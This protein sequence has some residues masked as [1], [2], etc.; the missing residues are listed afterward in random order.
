MAR[1]CTTAPVRLQDRSTPQPRSHGSPPA[2]R[3]RSRPGRALEIAGPLPDT[4][5]L[6]GAVS[7]VRL[8][9]LAYTEGVGGSS[10]SPPTTSRARIRPSEGPTMGSRRTC[11]QRIANGRSADLLACLRADEQ[12]IERGR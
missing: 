6:A 2:L 11:C 9:H 4:M 10:P 7:S 12:P 8:E 3:P 5:T 1:L